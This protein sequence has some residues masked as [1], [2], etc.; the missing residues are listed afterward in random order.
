MVT[1]FGVLIFGAMTLTSKLVETPNTQVIGI[2]SAIVVI[3][4]IIT[5][6]SFGKNAD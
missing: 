3:A 1:I 5:I 2:S 6:M 4:I